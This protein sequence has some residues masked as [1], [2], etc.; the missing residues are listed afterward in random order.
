MSRIS[1]F[2]LKIKPK[3]NFVKKYIV[4][5]LIILSSAFALAQALP[6]TLA[7]TMDGMSADLKA[8][9][10]QVNNAQANANSAALSDEFVQLVGHAKSFVPSLITALPAD[11]QAA[12][13]AQYD[14]MLDQTA[15]LGAQLAGA[16][17][18]NDNAKAN[19]LLKQ[20]SQA[21]HDG[22]DEFNKD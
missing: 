16:F 18:A 9:T 15:Q 19:V 22:H 10:A 20:L 8:V 4:S 11:Q 21:K 3:G 7:L 1:Q 6:N 5:T 17:R 12:A 14:K 13:K 2:I